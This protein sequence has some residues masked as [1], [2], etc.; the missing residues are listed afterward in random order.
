MDQAGCRLT[1]ADL[2]FLMAVT[3][4]EVQD[5]ARLKQLI[6]TDEDFREAFIG[7]EKVS[8]KVVADR[9]VFLKIS[10]RLY[11]EILLRQTRKALQ[12]ASF[13]IERAGT[14]KI[15]VFDTPEV[16][17][18]LCQPRILLYLAD[19]L[20][21]F[22]KIES[23]TLSY[24]VR[25]GIW[26]KI[27]FNTLD[28]DSLIRF[29]DAMDDLHQLGCLKRIADICLFIL[30]IFP[31]FVRYTHRYPFSGEVRPQ[32]PGQVR[33]SLEDYEEE[34][35]KFYRLA[36]EHP[37]AQSFE[38]AETFNLLHEKFHTAQKPLQFITEH[39]LHYHRQN[40]FQMGVG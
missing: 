26:R 16:V 27:R 34:G 10:P 37:V 24:R 35:R 38:L 40:L 29:C 18:L 19:M 17:D 3:A 1:D 8:Q 15:A 28:I 11:F 2:D 7:D 21:S 22:T 33:R 5:R 36:A 23:Y 30:G 31:E 14:Q 6:E 32:L 13:T 4:P 9:E 20:A 12:G 39:F 25:Q